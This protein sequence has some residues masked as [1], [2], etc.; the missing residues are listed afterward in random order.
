M[1]S[2][3]LLTTLKRYPFTPYQ[4]YH[5]LCQSYG[6]LL[7][8]IFFHADDWPHFECQNGERHPSDP[9]CR[10]VRNH[11][12]C[13]L[14]KQHCSRTTQRCPTDQLVTVAG[15]CCPSCLQAR[16]N[17][18]PSQNYLSP[19]TNHGSQQDE[20]KFHSQ[21]PNLDAHTYGSREVQFSYRTT[22]LVPSL[23]I[24]RGKRVW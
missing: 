6:Y 11:W 4:C 7:L 10:C 18:A 3:L 21:V 14:L 15:E 13:H 9:C 19:N 20:C 8:T 23:F 22:S 5:N 2:T 1:K 16:Q 12:E 17:T 24:A